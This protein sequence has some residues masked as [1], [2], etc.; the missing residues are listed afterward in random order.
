MYV[1]EFASLVSENSGGCQ[2]EGD[3]NT[4]LSN[5]VANLRNASGK[6]NQRD[7]ICK[8]WMEIKLKKCDN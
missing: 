3:H 7:Q 8:V 6:P 2:E 1:L 4:I 5:S